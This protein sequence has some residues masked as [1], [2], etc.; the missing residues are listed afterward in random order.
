M[1]ISGI[2]SVRGRRFGLEDH[3]ARSCFLI[4]AVI[5]IVDMV[6]GVREASKDI[7]TNI[8]EKENTETGS[9]K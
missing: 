9:T 7:K 3:L 1:R 5:M 2:R 6:V 4:G 8:A